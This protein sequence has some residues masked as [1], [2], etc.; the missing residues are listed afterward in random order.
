MLFVNRFAPM[1]QENC[2][3]PGFQVPTPEIYTEPRSGME[4]K[5]IFAGAAVWTNPVIG[6]VVKM[7]AWDNARLRIAFCGIVQVA[8]NIAD[9]FLA[10]GG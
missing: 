9:V 4:I 8:T 7:G 10:H 3:L 2:I 1:H 5:I 6:E